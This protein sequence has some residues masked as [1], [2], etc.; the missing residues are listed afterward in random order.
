MTLNNYSRSIVELLIK[1]TQFARNSLK[2]K[3]GAAWR[4]MFLTANTRNVIRPAKLLGSITALNKEHINIA[5]YRTYLPPLL[6]RAQ[7]RQF[8]KIKRIKPPVLNQI[9][10]RSEAEELSRIATPRAIRKLRGLQIYLETRSLRAVAEA[11]GHKTVNVRLLES[12]LPKPLMDYFNERWIRQ[13]QNAI[14]YEALK[15]SRYLFDALDFDESELHEFLINHGLGDLPDNL[16]KARNSASSEE[17]QAQIESI[18]E[19]V[20]TLST[21]LLQ[22]LIAIQ[23]VVEAAIKSDVFKPII[24]KWY[25]A[26]T[27]ILTSLNLEGRVGKDTVLLLEDAKN[28]PIDVYHFKENLLCH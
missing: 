7:P 15:D 25:E 4:Y 9:L 19:V 18:D 28:N 8:T 20:Y 27:F 11:L 17:N 3:G 22:V 23:S 26:A 10:N 24:E 2:K 12:Y 21:P 1:Q 14:V 13:F 16:S 6:S 5:S